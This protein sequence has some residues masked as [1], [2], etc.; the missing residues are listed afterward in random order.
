MI[1]Q[2]YTNHGVKLEEKKAHR[3]ND[4]TNTS[5]TPQSTSDKRQLKLS[6]KLQASMMT[7]LKISK[8]KV[9]RQ[10]TTYI[11]IFRWPGGTELCKMVQL[12][13]FISSYILLPNGPNFI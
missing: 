6:D 4:T 9:D 10:M 1:L 3:K 7:D 12:I 5:T 11:R 13:A 8:D 2:M